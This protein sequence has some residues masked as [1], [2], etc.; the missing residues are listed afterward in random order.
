MVKCTKQ[1]LNK[2]RL[3]LNNAVNSLL[4]YPILLYPFLFFYFRF[5]ISFSILFSILKHVL[6]CP[7]PL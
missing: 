3:V 2:S 7:K 6:T 1:I 5:S 4:F